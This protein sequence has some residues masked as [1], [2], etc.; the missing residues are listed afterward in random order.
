MSYTHQQHL[1]DE[2][3]LLTKRLQREFYV[4][5]ASEAEEENSPFF[6]NPNEIVSIF[7]QLFNGACVESVEIE[8]ME[9]EI[10]SLHQQI[11]NKLK[12]CKEDL[13]LLQLQQMFGLSSPEMN[14]LLVALAPD[15]DRRYMR[16]YGYL[17]D[18]MGQ[19]T[20]TV[21]LAVDLLSDLFAFKGQIWNLL[22]PC[23]PLIVNRLL[24]FDA[25]QFDS[26]I[27]VA[28]RIKRFLLK[29]NDV[30]FSIASFSSIEDCDV[31]QQV[32]L[33]KQAAQICCVPQKIYSL[34]GG[35]DTAKKY[36][37]SQVC[38][39]LS[40]RLLV[41]NLAHMSIEK[42]T[43]HLFEDIFREALLQKVSIVFY[44]PQALE[45]ENRSV[46]FVRAYKK[47][48]SKIH[49]PVFICDEKPFHKNSYWQSVAI[50]YFEFN[51]AYDNM[52]TWMDKL[53]ANQQTQNIAK[54]YPSLSKQQ[55]CEVIEHAKKLGDVL[56]E[57]AIRFVLKSY[58]GVMPV[59]YARKLK[60][61]YSWDD[62]VLPKEKK[63]HLNEI[64]HHIKYRHQVY[65]QW[66]FSEKFSVQP[67][68]NIMFIGASGTGKTM[69]A[70]VLAR[71]IG[72][73]I[74]KID[75][76]RLVSKYI[77]ETEKN[78]RYVFDLAAQTNAILFFDEADAI[79]G[80]RTTVKDAHDRYANISTNYLLQKLEEHHG[81]VI[82]A[83]NFSTNIDD[84]FLRR[85]AFVI[86]FP[87]PNEQQRIAL[88]RKMF[89]PQV[90]VNKID[91]S[92]LAREFDLCGG[93]IKNV[94]IGAAFL[95]ASE[96]SAIQMHHICTALKREYQKLGKVFSEEEV[97][98][99]LEGNI[100]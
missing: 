27:V 79:F 94:V 75:V 63:A 14:I 47:W 83:T 64:S 65:E 81:V 72:Q 24:Q 59:E 4:R 78:L 39:E 8:S 12:S 20:A 82:L 66:Q 41:I 40:C 76:S 46:F 74:Y 58:Y 97:L 16:I 100:I 18:D 51:D 33:T 5:Q 36:C 32:S 2:L 56:D 48:A 7:E 37:I 99:Y 9:D 35:N 21:S 90:P 31:S 54:D 1:Q 70:E 96:K 89:P 98:P 22:A 49:T 6:A 62:L 50:F 44:H 95:A 60:C 84:A 3:H 85:M 73:N 29:N 28:E 88:W 26:P 17:H 93:N 30:A 11:V 19:K 45:L 80:K 43:E 91:Y 34:Y 55:I 68:S 67:G 86:E 13:P 87:F 53:D 25:G 77:G 38:N 15:L 61:I 57:K 52:D 92:F 10:Q 42:T 71:E 23:S 69:A